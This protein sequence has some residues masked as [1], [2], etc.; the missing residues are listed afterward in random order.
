MI[1]LSAVSRGERAIRGAIHTV[2]RDA[3]KRAIVDALCDEHLASIGAACN[4]LRAV[5]GGTGLAVALCQSLRDSGSLVSAASKRTPAAGGHAVALYGSCSEATLE[6]V[7]ELRK[8][9][10][11]FAIDPLA[12]TG[13]VDMSAEALA[14]AAK[15]LGDQP[16][17]IHPSHESNEV[18]K[19]Q[20]ALGRHW[21][22]TTIEPL[23]LLVSFRE[24]PPL[25]RL[26]TILHNQH[27]RTMILQ[28]TATTPLT[29]C[30]SPRVHSTLHP[31]PLP[32]TS[33]QL[34]WHRE[35]VL[36]GYGN[37]RTPSFSPTW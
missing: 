34:A 32:P 6:Q 18:R 9:C 2:Q 36:G 26:E 11:S 7:E 5:T 1:P 8:L 31:R 28:R 13:G 15:K 30:L 19:V 33:A 12:T 37:V 21:S 35:I 4:D 20:T 17:L 14:W 16:L 22:S 10:P 24:L 29:S 27:C 23:C 3:T 25:H